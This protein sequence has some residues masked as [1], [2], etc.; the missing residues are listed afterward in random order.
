V[1]RGHQLYVGVCLSPV[2]AKPRRGKLGRP[3]D[4]G[5]QP[6]LFSVPRQGCRDAWFELGWTRQP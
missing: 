4:L 6:A 3:L 2:N 1:C 5:L